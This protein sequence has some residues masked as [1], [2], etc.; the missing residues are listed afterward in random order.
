MSG[1]WRFWTLSI[2]AVL[3][4][5]MVVDWG[6]ASARLSQITITGQLDPPKVVA[7]GTNSTMLT[8]VVTENG[9]PRV[10]TLLQSW[11]Q[12]GGGLLIPEW[13][14]TDAEGKAQIT[15]T[16][17]PANPYDLEQKTVI[18]VADTRVGWLIE[19][20]KGYEIEVPIEAP[21]TTE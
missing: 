7:D 10:H 9:R 11:L 21:L 20:V 12:T 18:H 5:A 13:A 15:Y 2:I 16:P 8:V 4:V 3:A 6:R 19:V 17:N 1:K 14:Y